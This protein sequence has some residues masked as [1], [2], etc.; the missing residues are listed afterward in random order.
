MELVKHKKEDE[1]I[2]L[3]LSNL[4][5]SSNSLSRMSETNRQSLKGLI[6]YLSELKKGNI[7]DE[8]QFSELIILACA[9]FIEIEVELRISKSLNDKVMF[10]F[11]KL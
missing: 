8:K 3:V 7:I 6:N 9:N 11:E 10:F 2:N 5:P 1:F 4:R